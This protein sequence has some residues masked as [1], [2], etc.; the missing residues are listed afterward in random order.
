MSEFYL[1]TRDVRNFSVELDNSF[2]ILEDYFLNF[3]CKFLCH[4]D[5]MVTDMMYFQVQS[6][7]NI[8]STAFLSLDNQQN[9][10]S[11]SDL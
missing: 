8:F 7:S 3:G 1:L 2:W 11:S 6:A 9:N 4:Y 5:V 10:N